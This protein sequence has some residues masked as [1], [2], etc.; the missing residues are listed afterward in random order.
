MIPLD[1]DPAALKPLRISAYTIATCLGAGAEATRRALHEGTSGLS[2][3]PFDTVEL[4]THTGRIE[5]LDERRVP[6]RLSQFDCRNNRAAELALGLDGFEAAVG[7]AAARH[8]RGRVGVF[9]G[10]S[11]AGI[12][13]TELAYRRRDPA[14]GA[15]PADFDYRGTQNTFSVATYVRARLGLEGPC[16]AVSTAC[17]SSAKVFAS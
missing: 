10:T 15:L 4:E 13:Q 3:A 14:S 11:T 1:P 5:G 6:V 17:S 9:I 8:G 12:L 7:R 2:P 16:S